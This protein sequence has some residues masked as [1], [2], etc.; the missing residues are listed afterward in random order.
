MLVI[1]NNALTSWLDT[2]TIAI[3]YCA[4]GHFFLNRSLMR[5]V[6]RCRSEDEKM[7]IYNCAGVALRFGL[8]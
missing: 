8:W 1:C 2:P 6:T 7:F 5:I 4:N 3:L